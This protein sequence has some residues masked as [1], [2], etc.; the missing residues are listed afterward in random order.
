LA[1]GV[2]DLAGIAHPHDMR[3]GRLSADILIFMP[4]G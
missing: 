3:V 4:S 1:G 2:D